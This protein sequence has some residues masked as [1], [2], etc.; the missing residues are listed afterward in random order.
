MHISIQTDRHTYTY[1]ICNHTYIYILHSL[2]TWLVYGMIYSVLP[3][4]H[5]Y[6]TCIVSMQTN[7]WMGSGCVHVH[8]VIA[9]R[10]V[11][12]SHPPTVCATA[13]RSYWPLVLLLKFH[14][15]RTHYDAFLSGGSIPNQTCFLI[16]FI[17]FF[18]IHFFFVDN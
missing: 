6:L 4:T 18:L 12:R 3:L 16:N 2:D 9:V 10:I 15:N 11:Y 14:P 1:L 13:L 7:S 5:S 8:H 17:F